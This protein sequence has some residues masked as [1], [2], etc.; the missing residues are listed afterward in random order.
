MC[1]SPCS[2]PLP[3][4]H[5]GSG[6]AS[7]MLQ[8]YSFCRCFPLFNS[9]PFCSVA[10]APGCEHCPPGVPCDPTTGACI[11]G[12]MMSVI[13]YVSGCGQLE[14]TNVLL[15]CRVV[16]LLLCCFWKRFTLWNKIGEL[17][18]LTKVLSSLWIV[19]VVLC[20]RSFGSHWIG[21]GNQLLHYVPIISSGRNQSRMAFNM[22]NFPSLLIVDSSPGF[23]SS[24]LPSYPPPS[25]NTPISNR[26]DHHDTT[27]PRSSVAGEGA[28]WF[29]AE[30]PRY[31]RYT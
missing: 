15:F 6:A 5:A 17:T 10:E 13:S 16:T 27:N 26:H 28:P 21:V 3:L 9:F 23:F 12:R 19:K 31:M 14:M 1:G 11:K 7:W 20:M 18:Y 25:T 30:P 2:T 24:L 8:S 22:S 29:S 4:P